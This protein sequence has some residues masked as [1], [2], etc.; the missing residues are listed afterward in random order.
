M[1]QG[2]GNVPEYLARKGDG[3][4]D[5]DET[6]AVVASV[7]REAIQY[8]EELGPDRAKATDYYHAEP[9]GIEEAGRSQ[10]VMSELRDGVLGVIPSVLRIV[11]GPEHTVEYVPRKGADVAGAE[12][13]TDYARYVYEE[14]NAGFMT[15]L[16]LL[17]DGLIKRIGIVKWG[18]DTRDE[19]QATA[20]K[21]MSREDLAELLQDERVELTRMSERMDGLMDV[22][23][24]YPVPAGHIWVEAV[25]TDDFFWNRSA[26]G[27][28]DAIVVGHRTRL[29][30]GE[31]LAMGI[32]ED[33]IELYAGSGEVATQ[34][35]IARRPN[36]ISGFED[37]TISEG[38]R[39]VIY[40]EAYIRLDSDGDGIP[41]LRKVCTIGTTYY[42]VKNDP[43]DDIPMAWWSPDPEPHAI[44]GG[45]YMDRLG[46]M[47]LINSQ[48]MRTILDGGSAASFPRM[49]YVDGQVSVADILNNAIGAPIRMRQ[50]G[51][52]QAMEVPFSAEKLLPVLG[53]MREVIERRIGQ[54]DGAG[55]LDMDALQSTGKEAVN[56]AI[57]AA[58]AQSELLARLF[59]EQI[60]KPMYR[61][62]LK[63]ANHPLS[64]SRIVRLRGNYVEVNPATW[65]AGM[66]VSVKVALGSMNAEKKISTLMA[67]VQDQSNILQ[68]FGPTNPVVTL[69][70]LRNAKAK[71]LE[72]QGIKDVENYYKAIPDD[73]Q[74]PPPPPAEPTEDEKWRQAEMKMSQ[75]KSLKELAIKQDELRLKEIQMQADN[76]FRE[77]DLALKEADSIRDSTIGPHN[78]EIER[79]KADLDA[80]NKAQAQADAVAIVD[81]KNA[82][83]LQK[84]ADEMAMRQ[85]ELDLKRHEIDSRADAQVLTASIRAK[86]TP[87]KV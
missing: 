46:D 56:A 26:R 5:D 9:F 6:H 22:E 18:M 64:K 14:D 36:A 2:T 15:T 86:P 24:N 48:L 45:S 38:N 75:E 8:I 82:M 70:M 83:E 54:K 67:V 61:G 11:H 37:L 63:L 23:V 4:M 74:P 49:A 59:A 12:Q 62:I 66:G 17:K 68:Q 19:M 69:A 53:T 41:E 60:L 10:V 31:L 40:C 1:I 30:R 87:P 65:D 3:P 77:R 13:A 84:H 25:P 32:D 57:T 85:A 7:I 72:L 42:P 39:K 16:S 52:V 55:S 20:Y 50:P 47:Q 78:A 44:L 34:E 76:A 33:V 21:G 29:T 81:A 35:E 27:K 58:T 73:Y 80:Q 43:A 28:K 71:I 51:M 79:Y